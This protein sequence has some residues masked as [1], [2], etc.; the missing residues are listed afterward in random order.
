MLRGMQGSFRGGP[1]FS[2]GSLFFCETP[3]TC[4]TME[5][6]IL[7][8]RGDWRSIFHTK[9]LVHRFPFH[10]I[11]RGEP[12]LTVEWTGIFMPAPIRIFSWI[13]LY[14]ACQS[15]VLPKIFAWY[16]FYFR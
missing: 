13:C 5:T 16:S 4:F 8:L 9:N 7:L 15:S 12:T 2:S 14:G 3:T 11:I 10:N 6:A 1:L